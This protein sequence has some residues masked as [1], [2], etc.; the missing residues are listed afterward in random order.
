[1]RGSTLSLAKHRRNQLEV[2]AA[3]SVSPDFIPMESK[4]MRDAAA[5]AA[6]AARAASNSSMEIDG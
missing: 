1:M 2:Q 6:R 3:R 5:R 4:R